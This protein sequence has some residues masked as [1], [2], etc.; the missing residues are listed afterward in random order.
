M[1]RSRPT[2]LTAA[3]LG[4]A[5]C[6]GVWSSVAADAPRAAAGDRDPAAQTWHANLEDGC[7][8]AKESRRA[9]LVITIWKTGT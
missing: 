5:L 8:A 7:S 3:L 9:V 6:A 4:A 1:N 2:V